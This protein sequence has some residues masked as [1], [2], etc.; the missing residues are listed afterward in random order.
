MEN[1]ENIITL[2]VLDNTQPETSRSRSLNDTFMLR[3][4]AKP[5]DFSKAKENFK[6]SIENINELLRDVKKE[7]VEGW[8]MEG[9]KVSLAISAEGSIGIATAGVEASFEIT[10]KSKAGIKQEK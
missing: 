5:L 6:K 3:A 10:F 9:V 7:A 2:I 8:E 4:M 1:K